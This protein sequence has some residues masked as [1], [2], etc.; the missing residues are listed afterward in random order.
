LAGA[1]AFY[2]GEAGLPAGEKRGARMKNR[3]RII[4]KIIKKRPPLGWPML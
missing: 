3:Y 2:G 4:E 1:F